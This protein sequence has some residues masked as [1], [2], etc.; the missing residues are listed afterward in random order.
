MKFVETM[1]DSRLNPRLIYAYNNGILSQKVLYN[2]GNDGTLNGI[3]E[4][5]YNAYG[6]CVEERYL[7]PSRQ[8]VNITR[9]EYNASGHCLDSYKWNGTNWIS[10][11]DP[12]KKAPENLATSPTMP[13]QKIAHPSIRNERA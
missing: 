8:L 11:K 9:H 12:N 1:L 10:Q 5:D 2:R 4:Y 7:T 3:S 13:Q 6:K